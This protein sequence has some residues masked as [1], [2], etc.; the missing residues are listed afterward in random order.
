[1]EI[2]LCEHLVHDA[3]WCDWF[4]TAMVIQ[5]VFSCGFCI[6]VNFFGWNVYCGRVL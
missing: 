3:N 1:M 2:M 5:S 4:I 6:M